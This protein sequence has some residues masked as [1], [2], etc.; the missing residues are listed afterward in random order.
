[1]VDG[2]AQVAGLTR[3]ADGN[4][5]VTGLSHPGGSAWLGFAQFCSGIQTGGGP[6]L[7]VKAFV[8][9][10]QAHKL[11]AFD[12]GQTPGDDREAHQQPDHRAFDGF[13][14]GCQ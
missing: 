11:H 12:Q 4:G 5:G 1:M 9:V 3:F 10:L 7:L 8:L 13:E 2:L 14:G 6:E